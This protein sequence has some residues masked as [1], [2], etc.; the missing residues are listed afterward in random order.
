MS[1]CRISSRSYAVIV[2]FLLLC[3]LIY[4]IPRVSNFGVVNPRLDT[5]NYVQLQREM[6]LRKSFQDLRNSYLEFFIATIMNLHYNFYPGHIDGN[7]IPPKVDLLSMAGKRRLDNFALS[8]ATV[9]QEGIEGDIVETGSW[10][11]GASFVAAKVIELMGKH[12]YRKVYICDSF[13]GIPSPP[14]DRVYSEEDSRANFPVFSDLSADRVR[15]DA[16]HFGIDP[17]NLQIV[18]GYFNESLPL[19]VAHNPLLKISVLRL[20][21][22]TYFST[23]DALRVLY[24]HLSAG[25]YVIVDDYI[26]W[27]GC[28]EAVEDYRRANGIRDP[29]VL[30]PHLSGEIL[31]GVYWRKGSAANIAGLR[32]APLPLPSSSASSRNGSATTTGSATRPRYE[33]CPGALL[34]YSAAPQTSDVISDV[35]S[36]AT[37]SSPAGGPQQQQL[38]TLHHLELFPTSSLR[39]ALLVD[40]PPAGPSDLKYGSDVFSKDISLKMCV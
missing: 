34:H 16:L 3:A 14:S 15:T 13:Q 8:V 38:S 25:G 30:V 4:N 33:L 1:L 20:D 39:P 5:N 31:R 7:I 27:K 18:E 35:I 11:G 21:G 23:M 40:V 36:G 12:P 29:I 32:A 26:D 37:T 17:S 10:R 9:L 22:D 28:R 24:P 19:L 6:L 2:A